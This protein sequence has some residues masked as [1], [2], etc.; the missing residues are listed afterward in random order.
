MDAVGEDVATHEHVEASS[1]VVAKRDVM[2]QLLCLL[3]Q[4][5]AEE[6]DYK[7]RGG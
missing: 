7:V 6:P 1:L 5:M 3:A 4:H 2:L